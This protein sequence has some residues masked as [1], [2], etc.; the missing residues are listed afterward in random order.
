[1]TYVS[2]MAH[3]Q[4][5]TAQQVAEKVIEKAKSLNTL[6]AQAFFLKSGIVFTTV[7][8]LQNVKVYAVNS[9]LTLTG[10]ILTASQAHILM[11][12]VTL[13]TAYHFYKC[14][15]NWQDK[16]LE[17]NTRLVME[18][19]KAAVVEN[20]FTQFNRVSHL[21]NT[22]DFRE[23]NCKMFGD[24]NV[25]VDQNKITLEVVSIIQLINNV[26][27]NVTT[28]IFPAGYYDNNIASQLRN[29][30]KKFLR[31][32]TCSEPTYRKFS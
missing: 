26:N 1:M 21:V 16:H 20:D 6:S 22:Y 12:G 31:D 15:C 30:P 9:L 29:M 23:F 3:P 5:L 28:I 10:T 27:D 11:I 13:A 4:N 18:V 14:V 19:L 32:Y 17:M 2:G 7:F 8:T 24:P 25:Q